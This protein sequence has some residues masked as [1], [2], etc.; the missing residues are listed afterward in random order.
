MVGGKDPVSAE[1]GHPMLNRA[2]QRSGAANPY[3]VALRRLRPA[4]VSV[5]LFS[6]LISLLMLTGSIYMLQVY[7]R[8]LSSGSVPTLLGLFAIVIVLYGFLGIYDFLRSR[9][10]SRAARLLDL[11][12]GPE[13]FRVWLRSGV[14]G[15]AEG[16]KAA[17]PLQDLGILRSFISGPAIVALFDTPFVPLFLAVLFLIHPWLGWMTVAGAGVVAGLAAVNRLITRPAIREAAALDGAERDFTEKGRRNAEA[18]IAMGMEDAVTRRWQALHDQTQTS[19][20]RGSDPSEVLASSSRAF[21]MLL[22]SA[23]LTL[24]AYLVLQNQMT[25]GMIVAASILSG[26]ALAPVD[27]V[28]GQWR[29]I[30]RALEAHRRLGGFFEERAEAARPRIDLP[31]PTGQ[32]TVSRLTKLAPGWADTRPGTERPRIL[33]QVSFSLEPGDGLG[34]IGNSAS[35]KSTLARL[36]MG[37][38]SPDAG[39]VR[40]DGATSDQWDPATLGRSVGYLPQA[41]DMLPGTIRDNIARFDADAQDAMVIEAAKLAGVH[42]MILGLPD[43]YATMLG[44]TGGAQPL[45][46]GQIQRLGLARAIYGRPRLVVLD[47]PNSNLDVAGDDALA[48]AIATLRANGSTV[49]VMAHR[50]SAIATVN[51]VLILHNGMVARFGDKDAVLT[52]MTKGGPALA[53]VPA[54]PATARAAAQETAGKEAPKPAPRT[55]TKTE[56]PA[57][58]A[59]TEPVF[60]RAAD[61]RALSETIARRVADKLPGNLAQ[62]RP[63]GNAPAPAPAPEQAPTEQ[64]LAQKPSIAAF[65]PRPAHH[66]A[67]GHDADPDTSPAPATGKAPAVP[68]LLFRRARQRIPG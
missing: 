48:R 30:G 52:A 20:Q 25:A 42:D 61:S 46:G 34:V 51:K 47:E 38:W 56:K 37:A 5:A 11:G 43:G 64:A 50:P 7:D 24:G 8:V 53:P 32:I 13:T 22:Q 49:I 58:N 63:A 40:L 9:M 12:A 27:Q 60:I 57:K 45:S 59:E 3:R 39:E 62:A 66:P 44:G 31:A 17:Q 15:G 14:P 33:H 21:R 41:L 10:L 6:A 36:I 2:K 1:P 35:G 28:I 54:A 55:A 16:E 19:G 26:R 29:S 4:V 18:V 68:P 67:P 23:I 65:A